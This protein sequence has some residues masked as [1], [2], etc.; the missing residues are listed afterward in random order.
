MLPRVDI[1]NTVVTC[2]QVK[3]TPEILKTTIVPLQRTS[4]C[5]ILQDSSDGTFDKEKRTQETFRQHY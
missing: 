5:K 3:I 2:K 4:T 1:K